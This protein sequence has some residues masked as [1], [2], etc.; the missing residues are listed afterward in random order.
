MCRPTLVACLALAV[1][2]ALFAA[3]YPE[4]E[5]RLIV[6]F[7]AGGGT[8]AVARIVADLA[9]KDLGQ[10]IV[11]MNKTG[12]AGAVG[13]TEGAR[14]RPDGYTVTMI[15]RELCSLYQVDLSLV[16]PKDFLPVCLVNEDPAVVLVPKNSPLKSLKDIVEGA[17]ARPGSLKFASSAQPNIYLLAMMTELGLSFNQIPY[18]GAGESIPALLGGHCDFTMVNPGEAIAQI[19]AGELIPLAVCSD[20]PYAGLPGVPTMR[21]LGYNVTA[22]TWRGLAVPPR[23]PREIAEKL[24]S[25]FK[26]A[27]DSPEF[28]KFMAD[29][30]LGVRFIPAAE[31][32]DFMLRDAEALAPIMKIVKAQQGK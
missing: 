2:G 7:A 32:M 22:S 8:D 19:R 16:Q 26:K 27:V 30:T 3:G 28:Q 12:G 4:K 29:R 13:M 23:T 6:P 18:G 1:S 10:P 5:I 24:E 14:S 20:G 11:I 31:Y 21:E 9:A 17:R 25:A 15:T